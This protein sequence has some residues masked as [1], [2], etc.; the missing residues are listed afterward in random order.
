LESVP[1]TLAPETHPGGDPK[2][3]RHKKRHKGQTYAADKI[4]GVIP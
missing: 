1:D 2:K 4:D 3:K